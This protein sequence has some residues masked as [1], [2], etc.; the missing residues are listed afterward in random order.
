MWGS[1]TPIVTAAL[2]PLTTVHRQCP[3]EAVLSR[4]L[5]VSFPQRRVAME[6]AD[7]KHDNIARLDA[8][9]DAIRKPAH[10][11]ATRLAMK[12]LVLERA[13]DH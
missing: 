6:M 7:A 13:F 8:I 1:A 5:Y 10:D 4:L 12:R 9:E 11:C 2:V 3:Y